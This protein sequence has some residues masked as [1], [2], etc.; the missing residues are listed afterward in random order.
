[1]ERLEMNAADMSVAIGMPCGPNIPWQTAMAIS[2]TAVACERRGIPF[3]IHLIA[4]SSLVTVARSA[5]LTNF[6]SGD[7]SRLFWVDSDVTWH[8]R[9]F[10]KALALTSKFDI[11]CGAYPTKTDPMRLVLNNRSDTY[12]LNDFGLVKIESTG[13]GFV[14]MKREV[15][16]KWAADKPRRIGGPTN[17]DEIVHAFTV[18]D[19]TGEDVQAFREWAALGYQAWLD[20]TIELGHIGPKVYQ[21]D[22]VEALGL[23]HIFKQEE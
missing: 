20:P 16:E 22:V 12:E 2:A 17:P 19:S 13:L 23:S 21:L 10:L 15:L 7:K 4:G 5:V 11:V 3:T 8:A 9:D 6:L 18:T 1:M 14:C